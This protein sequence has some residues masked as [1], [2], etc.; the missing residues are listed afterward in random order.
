VVTVGTGGANLCAINTDN[1]E[2]IATSCKAVEEGVAITDLAAEPT[3]QGVLREIRHVR[4]GLVS[5]IRT[6]DRRSLRGGNV[7]NTVRRGR[8]GSVVAPIENSVRRARGAGTSGRDMNSYY[9]R[10]GEGRV[11]CTGSQLGPRMRRPMGMKQERC[12][13]ERCVDC[14]GTKK[15]HSLVQIFKTLD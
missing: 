6:V 5:I 11:S 7:V 1:A 12:R 10:E 4:I 14:R 3:R 2:A 15:E 8:V 13:D 9:R